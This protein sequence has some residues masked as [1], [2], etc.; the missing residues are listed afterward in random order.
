MQTVGK[1]SETSS[2]IHRLTSGFS[3]FKLKSTLLIGDSL[4]TI[5]PLIHSKL[6]ERRLNEFDLA[7]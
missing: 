4:Y 2:L 5:T 3:L 7:T 1:Y 6:Q